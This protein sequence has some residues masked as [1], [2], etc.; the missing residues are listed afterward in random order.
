MDKNIRF[1]CAVCGGAEDVVVTLPTTKAILEKWAEILKTP[2]LLNAP[3]RKRLCLVH[4]EL[5][6]HRILKD[7]VCRRGP[8]TFPLEWDVSLQRN[9]SSSSKRQLPLENTLHN[10]AKKATNYD[11]LLSQ[12]NDEIDLL[13]STI[14]SLKLEI[15][16]KTREKTTKETIATLFSKSLLT[17]HQQSMIK[18]LLRKNHYSYDNNEKALCQAIYYKN[19]GAYIHLRSLLD[20][21]LPS[22]RTLIKWNDMSS[23]NVGVVR[24]VTGY[25]IKIKPSLEDEDRELVIGFDEMDGKRCLLYDKK[26]DMFIGFEEVFERRQKLAKKFLTVLVRGLSGKIGNLILANYATANGVTGNIFSTILTPFFTYYLPHG[27][28]HK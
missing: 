3:R 22:V 6:Y 2:D 12:K 14:K 21:K 8:F 18:L 7:P 19:S 13:N 27:P 17:D 15:S 28:T 5:Q 23:F 4:F 1:L 20:R 10:K 26:R 24:E 11:L 16:E 25:L 9:D